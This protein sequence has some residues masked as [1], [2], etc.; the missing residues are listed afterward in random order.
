MTTTLTIRLPAAT[1]AALKRQAKPTV[2]A[3]INAL[4][5]RALTEPTVNWDEHYDWLHKHGRVIAGHP[6]DEMRQLN[7]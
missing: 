6:C 1:K 3:W 7:R 5:D 2:N 4:I